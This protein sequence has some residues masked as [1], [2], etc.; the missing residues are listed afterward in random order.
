MFDVALA[1]SP[2]IRPRSNGLNAFAASLLLLMKL[3]KNHSF[4][5]IA[6]HFSIETQTAINL[7]YK[8]DMYYFRHHTNIPAVV[9]GNGVVNMNEVNKLFTNAFNSMSPYF[10]ELSD[11]FEDPTGQQR[12]GVFLNIDA[13]YLDTVSSNDVELQKSLY[14]LNRA[15]HT[16]KLTTLTNMMGKFLAVLPLSSS[17]SP[18]SGDSYLTSTYLNLQDQQYGRFSNY[19]RAILR[20]NQTYFTILACDAGYV[21]VS[22]NQP[23]QVQQLDTLVDVAAQEGCF[24]LHTST[25]NH[26]YH[27]ARNSRGKL[28][29]VAFDETNKTLTETTVRITRLIRKPMEQSHCGLKQG[30]HITDA[31]KLPNSYLMPH[32]RSKLRKYGIDIS[33]CNVCK[34]SY[35]AV[36]CCSLYNSYHPGFT[37]RYLN[38]NEQ[39]VAARQVISR[40]FIEN[41]LCYNEIWPI[42][43]GRSDSQWQRVTLNQ[44]AA[45]DILN[46]PKLNN[47]NLDIAIHLCGGVHALSKSDSVLTYMQQLDLKGLNLTRI[48][49][50]TALQMMPNIQFEYFRMNAEPPNWDSSKF[51]Q[52][53]NLVLVRCAVPPSNKSASSR[54]NYHYPVIAF[55]AG[56]SSRL[57]LP[58]P[59]NRIYF[60]YCVSCPSLNGLICMDKHLASLLKALSFNQ[61]YKSTARIPDMLN[62]VADPARQVI[63]ALPSARTSTDIPLNVQR[64]SRDTRRN[65]P[66]YSGSWAVAAQPAVATTRVGSNAARGVPTRVITPAATFSSVQTTTSS[67]RASVTTTTTTSA[68]AS[69]T[70]TTATAATAVQ[71]SSAQSVS[72][73]PSN[74]AAAPTST[75]AIAAV[76]VPVTATAVGS[77]STSV[78]VTTTAVTPSLSAMVPVTT[79]AVTTSQAVATTTSVTGSSAT[80]S[81]SSQ[82]RSGKAKIVFVYI[83]ENSNNLLIGQ[84]QAS[85]ELL[86][87]MTRFNA[88]THQPIPGQS[89]VRVPRNLNQ[90]RGQHLQAAGLINDGNTCCLISFILA[91][92]RMSLKIHILDDPQDI[93]TQMFLLVLNALPCPRSFSLQLFIGVWNSVNRGLI[94]R[95]FEDISSISDGILGHLPLPDTNNGIPVLTRYKANYACHR[96]GNVEQNLHNWITKSFEKIPVINVPDQAVPID[97]GVLLTTFL[98]TTF[99]IPCSTCGSQTQGHYSY[100]RGLFTVLRLNRYDQAYNVVRTRLSDNRGMTVGDGLIGNLISCVSHMGHHQAGHYVSYHRADSLWFRNSDDSRISGSSLHPFYCIN[101]NESVNFLVYQNG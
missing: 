92:H 16:V 56:G 64:R 49:L 13:T 68:R 54:A 98:Q 39:I 101:N 77:I 86:A 55:G 78:L 48:Q 44:L 60:W 29:K 5:D 30:Y 87:V 94:I 47:N 84:W 45:N 32:S 3:G 21:M 100:D 88:I 42:Q 71:T 97:V 22:R 17:Q 63:L 11:A 36:T 85:G 90:F 4:E 26:P 57:G 33:F 8:V 96:C 27:I 31:K 25:K 75:T 12:R 52:W 73:I 23:T 34:M 50:S 15:G 6:S 76:S 43:L 40:M 59:Y 65:D 72:A 19:L 82:R 70:S 51:G 2:I 38:H 14:Y 91:C 99:D 20:G 41:P 95:Q 80:L 67:A 62:T 58:A 9:D 10:A 89:P 66:L 18:S 35:I 46:F 69:V 7:F 74:V 1:I 93:R 61:V 53:Q 37:I 79:T 28:E 83:I 24:L 81:T